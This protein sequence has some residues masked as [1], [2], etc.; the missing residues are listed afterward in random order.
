MS[1]EV[2][3]QY[4]VDEKGEPMVK[5]LYQDKTKTFLSEF[6]LNRFL[7]VYKG[8]LHEQVKSENYIIAGMHEDW[9]YGI[10][11]TAEEWYKCVMAIYKFFG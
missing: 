6:S 3:V 11:M 4:N 2:F 8:L 5:L 1:Q 10:K 9:D 7:G